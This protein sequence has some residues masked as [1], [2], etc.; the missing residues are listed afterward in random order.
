MF[1]LKRCHDDVVV[2]VVRDCLR[3]RNVDRIIRISARVTSSEA[4]A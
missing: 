3:D 4:V 2:A 1:D